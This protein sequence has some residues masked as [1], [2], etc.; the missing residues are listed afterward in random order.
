MDTSR[1]AADILNASQFC[2]ARNLRAAWLLHLI[3]ARAGHGYDIDRRLDVLGIATRLSGVY[4]ALRGFERDGLAS[5]AMIASRGGP[6]R[7]VYRLTPEGQARLDTITHRLA[8]A[9]DLQQAFLLEY[10]GTRRDEGSPR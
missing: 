9:R 6:A 8:I 3:D 4:R 2:P 5:S 10:D 7:R 1:P